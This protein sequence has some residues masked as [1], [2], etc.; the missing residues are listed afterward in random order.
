MVMKCAGDITMP[1]SAFPYIP[2]WFTL[3]QALAELADEENK[4]KLEKPVPW[5]MLVFSAQNQLLGIVRRQNILEGLRSSLPDKLRDQF[6]TVSSMAADLDLYRMSFSEERACQDLRNQIERK[7]IEFM[8]P[9]EATVDRSDPA[10]IAIYLMINHN[11]TF[12]PVVENGRIV[13]IVYAEDA[14]HEVI[15]HIV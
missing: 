1:L 3:R 7:I 10:L 15:T 11:L 8:T 14:L 9:I 13:G 2:Y 12:V 6:P 5:L 4:R